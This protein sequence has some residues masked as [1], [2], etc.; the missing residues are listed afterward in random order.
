MATAHAQA[1]TDSEYFTLY[2]VPAVMIDIARCESGLEQFEKDGGVKRGRVNAKDVGLFQINEKYWLERAKAMDIDIYT[3]VGN[4][5][6]ALYIYK[7]RG[8]KDWDASKA[9][10]GAKIVGSAPDRA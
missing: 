7:N 10:W 9:C 5:Q 4:I 1:P 6:M 8:T 2:A 3:S